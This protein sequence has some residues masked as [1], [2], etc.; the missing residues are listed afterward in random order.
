MGKSCNSS[1]PSDEENCKQCPEKMNC[2]SHQFQKLDNLSTS[3]LLYAMGAEMKDTSAKNRAGDEYDE[4]SINN[5]EI[6]RRFLHSVNPLDI[7]KCKEEQV[8]GWVITLSNGNLELLRDMDGVST[9]KTRGDILG[10]SE[11]S[12]SQK[13]AKVLLDRLYYMSEK[14]LKCNKYPRT[15]GVMVNA[16]DKCGQ[17]W[18]LLLNRAEGRNSILDEDSYVFVAMKL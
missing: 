3:W 17:K 9:C 14:I 15:E 13:K 10:E 12:V 5:V 1:C 16:T 7:E 4:C 6:A 18:F 8:W 2:C 11:L